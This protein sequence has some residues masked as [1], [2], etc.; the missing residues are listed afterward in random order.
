M[1][2]LRPI[3]PGDQR[4]PVETHNASPACPRVPQPLAADT[5]APLCQPSGGRELRAGSVPFLCLRSPG[6]ELLPPCP[7][8]G[9]ENMGRV[10]GSSQPPPCAPALQAQ[11]ATRSLAN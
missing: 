9:K 2:G 1:G 11:G 6:R 3:P 10:E 8:P 4:H 5:G 7:A